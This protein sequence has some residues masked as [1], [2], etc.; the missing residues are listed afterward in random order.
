MAVNATTPPT[1]AGGLTGVIADIQCLQ[2]EH[3]DK[4]ISRVLYRNQRRVA[5]QERHETGLYLIDLPQS[6]QDLPVI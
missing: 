3:P 5:V 4:G 2:A 6:S 1:S